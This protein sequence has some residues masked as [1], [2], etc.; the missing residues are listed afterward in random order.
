MKTVVIFLVAFL[1]GCAAPPMNDDEF[2]D[3]CYGRWSGGNPVVANSDGLD[4]CQ[5]KVDEYHRNSK[6]K[7][8]VPYNGDRTPQN[9]LFW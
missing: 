9:Y 4:W 3:M 5:K 8:R 7:G 1:A 6:L 2:L